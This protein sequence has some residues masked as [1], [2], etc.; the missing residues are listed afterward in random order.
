MHCLASVFNLLNQVSAGHRP[1]HAWFL[2]IAFV[3]EDDVCMCVH[4]QGH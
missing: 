1:V 3:R 2:E 4:P